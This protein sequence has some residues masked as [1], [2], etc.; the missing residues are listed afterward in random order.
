MHWSLIFDINFIITDTI[1][2]L[3]T[4]ILRFLRVSV[5]FFE[6]EGKQVCLSIQSSHF[7]IT[8]TGLKIA[9]VTR[10]TPLVINRGARL[11]H[12]FSTPCD[13][14]CLCLLL[15]RFNS[16]DDNKIC[17]TKMLCNLYFSYHSLY[18]VQHTA[19]FLVK[20]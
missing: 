8:L 3:W 17:S 2:R 10:E 11:R 12:C 7:T 9:L 1:L 15:S 6:F 5:R 20:E 13:S 18:F 14:S 4:L 16:A 19:K